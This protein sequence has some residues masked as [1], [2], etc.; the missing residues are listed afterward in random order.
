MSG[1]ATAAGDGGSSDVRALGTVLGMWAHPDDE[2]FLSAGLMAAA[3]DAGQRVVCV[4]ATLGERGTPDPV[5]W[6]PDRLARTRAHELRASLAALDVRE[7]HLLGMVDGTCAEQPF[8]EVVDRLAKLIRRIGPDTIITFGPDGLTGHSDHQTVSAWATAA[9]AEAAPS[10]R[11]LYATTTADF[12]DRWQHV[13]DRLDIFLADGLPLRMPTDLVDLQLAL[14]GE[15][16]D[17]KLVALRAHATQ[18]ARMAAALGDDVLREWWSV[19]TFIDAENA[20][21]SGAWGTWGVAA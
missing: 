20:D 10:A 9:R 11:L 5:A 1:D 7:H 14:D 8:G 18:T 17:R 4:T 3:R 12:V 21:T 6:P 2:T 19:E 16:A 15:S 13:H